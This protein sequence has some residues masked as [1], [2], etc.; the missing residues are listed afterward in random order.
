MTACQ[1][2]SLMKRRRASRLY[3]CKACT[4]EH[5]QRS[6]LIWPSLSQYHDDLY[7]STC[8]QHCTPASAGSCILSNSTGHNDNAK[9]LLGF[10]RSTKQ[11][12]LKRL[13]ENSQVHEDRNRSLLLLLQC[14]L[15][16]KALSMMDRP[17]VASQYLRGLTPLRD[18]AGLAAAKPG[19]A[20][21]N[22]PLVLRP[23]HAS[24]AA[25]LGRPASAFGKLADPTLPECMTDQ[26][27]LRSGF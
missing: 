13:Q 24:T 23:C 1:A 14:N 21:L 12:L 20:R 8:R 7:D 5:V 9:G 11:V 26:M 15:N 19:R 10:G 18:G 17:L 27:I 16:T 2:M 3:H 6:R 22:C 25:P 4:A